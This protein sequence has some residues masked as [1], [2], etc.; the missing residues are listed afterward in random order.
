[1]K[2]PLLALALLLSVSASPWAGTVS[3]RTTPVGLMTLENEGRDTQA[4]SLPLEATPV[5]VGVVSSV[6]KRI[7]SWE[8]GGWRER[9]AR[10]YRLNPFVLRFIDGGN[11]GR[12]F[13]IVSGGENLVRLQTTDDL[14]ARVSGGDRFEILPADTLASIFG[15]DG[16]GLL[17][18]S[19]PE[20]VDNVRLLENGRWETYY[21]DG[22]AWR[23]KGDAN[24][25]SRNAT[26]VL[27]GEGFLLVKRS[28]GKFDLLV[29]GDVPRE[30]T[31]LVPSGVARA[32]VGVPFA[33]PIR[34]DDL[35][36]TKRKG[37]QSVSVLGESG[38]RKFIF[39][40]GS[41]VNE[42]GARTQLGPRLVA[43][44]AVL[45]ERK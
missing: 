1:M 22:R 19:D 28:P 18:G 33:N 32:L 5:Y 37:W 24:L 43:G 23:L 7:V 44:S 27:P 2:P 34:L 39:T 25:L 35:G 4:L 45:V 26:P 29:T 40:K 42:R 8:G 10:Q 15:A 21:H 13:V 6:G 17:A 31:A 16:G 3:V 41:W 9:S 30:T 36:L 20:I 38:W 11:A 14:T 12:S